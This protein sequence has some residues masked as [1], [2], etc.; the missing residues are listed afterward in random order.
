MSCAAA[1]N[2]LA[3]FISFFR[4]FLF[5]FGHNVSD[6][7]HRIIVQVIGDLRD[8]KSALA[9]FFHSEIKES[10]VI[11]FKFYNSALHQDPVVAAQI[12]GGDAL[13]MNDLK[14]VEGD[15]D[16]IFKLQFFL[17]FKTSQE[18]T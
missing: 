11:C 17:F 9:D 6:S 15:K 10:A 14:F 5:V 7:H 18:N 12:L 1:Q 16:Q 2:I 4:K 8:L 13:K 3:D